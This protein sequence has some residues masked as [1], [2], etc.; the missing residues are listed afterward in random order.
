[1]VRGM[2]VMFH[3]ITSLEVNQIKDTL[4]E[5]ASLANTS[6]YREEE[7]TQL[8]ELLSSL[9]EIDTGLVLEL[10]KKVIQND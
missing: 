6:E 3:L 7:V 4:E 1:M 9:T 10:N 2:R 8:I 5:L